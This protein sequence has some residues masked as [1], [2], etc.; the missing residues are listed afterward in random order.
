MKKAMELSILTGCRIV[1]LI[2]RDRVS[3]DEVYSYASEG[4]CV[5]SAVALLTGI[6]NEEVTDEA[7]DE[8]YSAPGTAKVST[9]MRRKEQAI[10]T[11]E[12]ALDSARQQVDRARAVLAVAQRA[13]SAA[14]QQMRIL[15]ECVVKGAPPAAASSMLVNPAGNEP[16]QA[17]GSS[18]PVETSGLPHAMQSI[19]DVNVIEP[20]P[21]AIFSLGSTTLLL[22]PSAATQL[23]SPSSIFGASSLLETPGDDNIFTPRTRAQ[24]QTISNMAVGI[25]DPAPPAGEP[26]DPSYAMISVRDPVGQATAAQASPQRPSVNVPQVEAHPP[27]SGGT[28]P[29]AAAGRHDSTTP[30]ARY[31][32]NLKL[33]LGSSTGRSR[34]QSASVAS[35]SGTSPSLGVTPSLALPS[36]SAMGP[37]TRQLLGGVSGVSG[38]P[39]DFPSPAPS[40]AG[41]SPGKRRRDDAESH[42]NL[43][44]AKHK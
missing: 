44:R 43:K 39:G 35:A 17:A 28:T 6:P 30:T 14:E 13:V 26:T 5:D 2:S 12:E 31:K 40:D 16:S 36:S 18:P 21:S 11:A 10:L 15:E 22:P 4:S 25:L 1:L 7:Y 33:N 23:L 9:A 37:L 41:S 27:P 29:Q 20:P 19:G 42:A 8:H 24:L 32:K 34:S 3:A 38:I